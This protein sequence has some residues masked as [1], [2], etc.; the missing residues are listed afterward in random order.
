LNLNA[1]GAKGGIIQKGDSNTANL[2]MNV[3]LLL[4]VTISQVG[5]NITTNLTLSK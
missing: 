3:A 5:S 4:P 2:T 1:T